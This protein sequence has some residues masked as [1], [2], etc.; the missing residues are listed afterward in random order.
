MYAIAPKEDWPYGDAIKKV[1]E[2]GA[3]IELKGVKDVTHCKKYSVFSTPAWMYKP[4]SYADIH[5][6]IGKLI[7]MLEKCITR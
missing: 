6:G 7:S 1:E 2:M 4:A 3:C 5:A